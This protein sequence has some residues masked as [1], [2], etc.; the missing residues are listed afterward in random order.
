MEV[1]SGR[2]ERDLR[3]HAKIQ[4][5]LLDRP[6]VLTE[7]Y[8]SLRA[9][10][11]AASTI[12]VYILNIFHFLAFLGENGKKEDFYKYVDL[13]TIESYI[14]SMENRE[15]KNGL[16]RIG[17][18]FAQQRWSILNSLFDFL[19][20]RRYISENPVLSISR[21]QN[22]TEHKVTFLTKKE[23]GKLLAAAESQENLM[24]AVRD[25][26]FLSLALATGLRLTAI[27][28][29][30]VD[31][32]DFENGWISVV[33]KRQK[34]RKICIGENLSR[35]LKE[36]M[37]MRDEIFFDV[38]TPALFISDFKERLSENGARL[39][40]ER[41]CDAAK[42]RRITPH[43]LRSSAACTLVKS[44]VPIATIAEQLGHTNVNTTMRYIAS[45]TEDNERAKTILDN[46]IE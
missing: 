24:H 17:D 15:T 3:I 19:T 38:D 44:G 7:Y 37:I 26:A 12:N 40:L 32:V 16:K 21:P 9:N 35:L 29:I 33:E 10:R 46:I 13:Y 4:A 43:K 11:K 25:K 45:F 36:W 28:D 27:L 6:K 8:T 22:N 31:D 2:L 5:Q 42:I 1:C 18:D 23:V 34:V 20:K 39:I 41:C 30:N 14:I